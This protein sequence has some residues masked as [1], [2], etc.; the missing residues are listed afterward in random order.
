MQ[1]EAPCPSERSLRTIDLWAELAV[2]GGGV[3]GTCTAISAAREGL[4]VVLIQDRPVLGGNGSSEVR[5]WWLGATCHGMTNNRWAREPGIVNELLLENLYHN[6]DGNPVMVDRVLL[7]AVIKESNI[8]LLLNTAVFS[9]SKSDPET[10]ESITAYNAQNS[11]R[12]EVRAPLFCDASGDGILGFMSGAAFRMGAEKPEEFNEPLAPNEDFG[13]LLGDSIYFY[14]KDAGQP[15][16]FEPPSFARKIRKTDIHMLKYFH[17][18]QQGCQ[19]WWIE[20]GGRRDTVHEAEGIKWDLWAIVY[21]IWDY[22][23][24]SGEFEDAENLT[25]EWIGQIPGKRESRRFEGDYMLKQSDVV[26]ATQQPDVVALG[27]WAIDLHPADG[28]FSKHPPAIQ[29]LTRRMYPIP[30]RCLYSRNIK[31][32]FLGGRTHSASHVAFGSTRVMATLGQLGD[33]IGTAAAQCVHNGQTPGKLE[34]AKLQE[35]LLTKG[36]HL[37]GFD[38]P[39]PLLLPAGTQV[40]ASSEWRPTKLPSSDLWL[41]LKKSTAQMLPLKKGILPAVSF[42]VEA[43]VDTELEV[44]WRAPSLKDSHTPDVL[45][46]KFRLSCKT[47]YNEMLIPAK[48]ELPETGYAFLILRANE[49]VSVRLSS[50]KGTGLAR[51]NHN[52]EQRR[53]DSHNDYLPAN[54]A[55]CESFELW[56]RE[57]RLKFQHNLA[58]K[59]DQPLHGFSIS[60]VTRFPL[61]PTTL[62][63]AWVADTADVQPELLISFDFPANI[64]SLTLHLDPDWDHPLETVIKQHGFQ[65]IPSLVRNFDVIDEAGNCFASVRDNRQASVCVQFPDVQKLRSA[66]KIRFLQPSSG[67][68]VAVFGVSLKTAD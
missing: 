60:N 20:S 55:G 21:G 65:V 10:I 33:V 44:E 41:P 54:E 59:L 47:G 30:F 38:G 61:R 9:A 13:E 18:R 39:Y 52:G 24:N 67:W 25:L 8:T 6:P 15:V 3:A 62:P 19:L 23:K 50:Q 14:S 29:Y 7:D 27:G 28:S 66:I 46:H 56:F 11:T 58:L 1:I 43:S 17:L 49:Q 37:P 63:N 32:L 34:T 53:G 5:L 40:S 22:I 64:E 2:V 36:F 12:Y 68:P 4:K 48:A 45:L 16:P 57:N 42:E 31:N 35:R 51:L 26:Q